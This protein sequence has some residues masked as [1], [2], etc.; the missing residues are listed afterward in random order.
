[1]TCPTNLRESSKVTKGSV[2]VDFSWTL[3]NPLNSASRVQQS[4]TRHGLTLIACS[5]LDQSQWPGE[6]EAPIALGLSHM[7][8]AWK[9]GGVPLEHL[10][11]ELRVRALHPCKH[12]VICHLCVSSAFAFSL[13][14]P[15][16]LSLSLS[17]LSCFF[18]CC[19]QW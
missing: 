4:A 16:S 5:P 15:L 2:G 17:S 1:M 10:G 12:S 13:S 11:Q 19:H 7:L 18:I 9:R 14:L 6:C 8:Y 3:E